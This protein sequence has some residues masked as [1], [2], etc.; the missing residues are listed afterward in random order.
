[1]KSLNKTTIFLVSALIIALASSAAYAFFFVTM[2]NKNDATTAL[3]S[4]IEELSGQESSLSSSAAILKD[5][6]DKIDKLNSYFFDENGI[7]EFTQKIEALGAQS[8]TSVTI[9]SLDPATNS[10][11]G[12]SLNIRLRATGEFKNVERL[13]ILLENFPG[14]FEWSTFRLVRDSGP[15]TEVTKGKI[16]GKVL[17]P[18]WS[19]EI[20]LSALNFIK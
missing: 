4:K 19:V 11:T 15:T 17:P 14:K 9:Q 20:S 7:V 2:K 16:G 8:G 18:V 10:K 3:T 1:M 13:I 5:E 12:P 6:G